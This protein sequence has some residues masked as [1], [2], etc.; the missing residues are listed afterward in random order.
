MKLCLFCR[1][2][3]FEEGY[4]YSEYTYADKEISC[5]HHPCYNAPF[6]TQEDFI[7]WAK[8]AESCSKYEPAL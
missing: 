5:G 3:S 6:N 4:N 2:C 1:K 7:V 8:Q